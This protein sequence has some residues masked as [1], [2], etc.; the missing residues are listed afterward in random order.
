MDIEPICLLS[1]SHDNNDNDDD[2]NNNNKH[3]NNNNDNDNNNNNNNSRLQASIL[4]KII[5]MDTVY[6]KK[7][8]KTRPGW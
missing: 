4:C 3:D 6:K 7:T 8:K 1:T 2:D 5:Y